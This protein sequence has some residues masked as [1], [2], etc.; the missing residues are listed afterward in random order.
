[1]D[2]LRCL[3]LLNTIFSSSFLEWARYSQGSHILHLDQAVIERYT[4]PKPGRKCVSLK[5]K[6]VALHPLCCCAA[7]SASAGMSM[8]V[9]VMFVLDVDEMQAHRSDQTAL[10]PDQRITGC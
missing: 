10:V 4:Q 2:L 1:M 3:L 6:P 5:A 8:H 9:L 7:P